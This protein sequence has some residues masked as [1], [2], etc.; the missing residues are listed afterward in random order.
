M[1]RVEEALAE[2]AKLRPLGVERVPLSE[3]LGRVLADPVHARSDWPPFETSAMDGYAVRAADAASA[4]ASLRERPGLVAAGD[5]PPPPIEP[6]EA[7]RV[8]TGAPLPGNT[9]AVVPVERAVREEGRVRLDEAPAPGAHIRRRGES[10]AA[11]TRLLDAGR[12][13]AASDVA[14]AALAGA[15]PVA[16]FREPRVVIAV[17]GNEI[18]PVSEEPG[19]GR[20]RDS[21]G[22]MLAALCRERGVSPVRIERRRDDPDSVAALFA[23]ASGGIDLLLT[24]GGVSAGDLDL[25]P[26][27]AEGAGFELVFRGVS[28]RPGK[29]VVFGRRGETLWLGLPGNPVSSAVTFHLFAREVLG[30][31]RGEK[32]PAAPRLTARLARGVGPAG[33]RETYRDGSWRIEEGESVVE[34]IRSAGSHDLAAHAR[35]NVLVRLPA[36]SGPFAPGATVEC[37]LIGSAPAGAPETGTVR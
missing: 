13:L 10:V 24:T 2:L 19:P 25:L 6:G 20:L 17:T 30:R 23:D 29:P 12:R 9:G 34:P 7:V 33:P 21:N 28:V 14:L 36:G 35:A 26:A 18:V 5:P 16:L 11:G 22:P 15:D 8:M 37:L 31:L 32:H 3:A 1:I 4:G 27:A